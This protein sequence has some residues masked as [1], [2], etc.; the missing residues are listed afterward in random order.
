MNAGQQ[1]SLTLVQVPRGEAQ[2]E[3]ASGHID[4]EVDDEE[5]EAEDEGT[6]TACPPDHR[7]GQRSDGR[8]VTRGRPPGS[9]RGPGVAAPPA[10]PSRLD[11]PASHL[12]PTLHVTRTSPIVPFSMTREAASKGGSPDPWKRRSAHRIV[13]A[14]DWSV[15]KLLLAMAMG[16]GSVDVDR[17]AL[18][19][20]QPLSP[21]SA[22]DGLGVPHR[23]PH[24]CCHGRPLARVAV[25][26]DPRP[27]AID[28]PLGR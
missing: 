11:S 17:A 14:G 1:G 6:P 3:P 2:A 16:R 19:A 25:L 22:R 9:P 10:Q 4:D 8:L 28:R 21:P 5:P 24:G 13:N 27:G 12:A 18:R 15:T 26:P 7:A 20:T 23:A